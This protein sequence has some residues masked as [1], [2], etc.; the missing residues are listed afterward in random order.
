MASG[1]FPSDNDVSVQNHESET[2]GLFIHEDSHSRVGAL[3]F[4]ACVL[5][6]ISLSP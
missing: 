6:Y 1:S 5:S 3:D 4:E 2:H